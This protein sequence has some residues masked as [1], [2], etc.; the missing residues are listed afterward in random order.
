MSDET[1]DHLPHQPD[2][3]TAADSADPLRDPL[4]PD[5]GDPDPF[6]SSAFVPEGPDPHLADAPLAVDDPAWGDD[7]SEGVPESALEPDGRDDGALASVPGPSGEVPDG[8]D[9]TTAA[10]DD[11]WSDGGELRSAVDAGGSSFEETT[12]LVLAALVP[13]DDDAGAAAGP[14]LEGWD[15]SGVGLEPTV[16][17]WAVPVI[18]PDPDFID[19]DLLG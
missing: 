8:D 6:D 4:N 12:H 16:S 13:V 11:G 7:G 3:V 18:D 14:A 1:G 10:P 5:D 19:L 9:P 15:G 2:F 17:A